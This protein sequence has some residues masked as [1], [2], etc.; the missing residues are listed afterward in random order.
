MTALKKVLSLI[1]VMVLVVSTLVLVPSASAAT[2]N[3]NQNLS[4]KAQCC[5]DDAF[6]VLR[7]VNALRKAKGLKE[8]K[9]NKVFLDNAMQRAAELALDFGHTRPDGSDCF[10]VNAK[11]DIRAENIGYAYKNPTDVVNGWKS[12]SAHNA[13]MMRSDFTSIGIG[14]VIH[15]GV[16]YWV[17][18]F[19]TLNTDIIT[20][21]PADAEKA[22]SISLGANTFDLTFSMPQ[23]LFLT[24]IEDI[25][26]I[27]KNRTKNVNFVV[28]SESLTYTS[29]DT[30]VISISGNSATILKKGTSTI[31]AKNSAVTL[32][33]KITVDKFGGSNTNKCGDNITWEYN[34]GTLTLSGSGDMY[35]YKTVYDNKGVM[36]STNLPF[37]DGFSYV[38]KV[39]IEEGITSVGDSAFTFF[40]KLK[41][42]KLPSTL[43]SIGDNAF[44]F[45]V[46]LDNVIIP[47]SVASIGV[48]AFRKCSELANITLP[49]NLREISNGLFYS[50]S[51]LQNISI[52]KSVETIGQSAFA[53]CTS[54]ESFTLPEALEVLDGLV[55]IN[56]ESIKE[57][58]IPYNVTKI[59]KKAFNGCKSLSKV[60]MHNPTTIIE[61]NEVFS[62]TASTLTI[63]GYQNSSAQKYCTQN[64]V[65]F[66]KLSGTTLSVASSGY[67]VEYDTRPL[68]DDINITVA[69][70]SDYEVRYS[71]GTKFDYSLS[72]DSIGKL[73]KYFRED[74][75]YDQKIKGY[76]IDSGTYP[77]AFCVQ[78]KGYE[79][80]FGTVNITITKAT[81]QFYF[82][83]KYADMFWYKGSDNTSGLINLLVDRGSIEDID[84]KYAI[85][86][87]D[88]A[89]I[90]WHG[91]VIA[92]N[93]GECTVSVT[94]EGNKNYYAHSDSFKL[95]IYPVGEIKIGEYTYEFSEDKTAKIVRYAEN[96][97]KVVVPVK[98]LDYNI[99]SIGE[100][101]YY[102]RG[103]TS[104]EIP[105][106]IRNIGKQAFISSYLLSEL[107][108]SNSVEV[109]DDYA[110][111]GCRQLKSVTIPDSVRV[112]GEKAFGYTA[113][114][115]DGNCEK[116]SGFVIS[117]YEE[118]A[119][120]RYAIENDFEFITLEKPVTNYLIGDVDGD[121]EVSIMDATEIQ[122]V[123]A[124]MKQWAY[125][126]AQLAADFDNDT[127]VSIMDATEIQLFKAGLK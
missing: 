15:N 79:P 117:G 1:L 26:V 58:T 30:S 84:L 71:K 54:L 52:P 127:A 103:F 24:D 5:Y 120:Q 76:M 7:Q 23:K 20:T 95:K 119:A 125:E 25:E 109:I 126:Y 29:S 115:K 75:V 114:D 118:S 19:G 53:Y 31:T 8:L 62:G 87:T 86:N 100:Q 92:K 33:S 42:V 32:S 51:N 61:E 81:P 67:S 34:N 57:V 101:A 122:L 39:V 3:K 73:G 68:A 98:I 37:E 94:F 90:D 41:E 65:K 27:G 107:E 46:K 17:Q 85:D 55:F 13:N 97:D 47:H 72:F 38:E 45:C 40:E 12:S 106:G 80:Y 116:I 48:E 22:F 49:E 123:L 43:E 69:N 50:C 74:V 77:V 4:I 6:E 104:L 78:S 44:A 91:K 111:A 64:S 59:G 99:L 121:G 9:M 93:Y 56:C 102:S 105:Y 18:E 83:N 70:A 110:F 88:I 35:D 66:T 28:N 60:T 16:R 2:T 113:P 82:E 36:T 96:Y 108:L 14:A 124:Q 112:I 11:D 63:L 10:T 89:V 21:A